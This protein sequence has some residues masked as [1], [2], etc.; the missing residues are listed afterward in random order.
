MNIEYF[1]T[2][3][4]DATV[5]DQSSYP[6]PYDCE[7]LHTIIVTNDDIDYV[8][9]EFSGDE[10]AWLALTGSATSSNSNTYP[11]FFFQK[12]NTYEIYPASSEDDLV[13]TLRYKRTVRDMSQ[14]DY[15]T[16]TIT[17]LA[18]AGTAV[19]GNG[20]TWTAGFVG[21]Y[22]KIDDDGYWYEI[23]ARTSNT[24]ITLLREYGGTAIAAGTA[25]YTIGEMSMLPEAYQDAPI[26][27]ALYM[28]YMIKEKA[29]LAA[30]YK[31]NF[32]EKLRDIKGYGSNLT[33]SGVIS[34]RGQRIINPNDYPRNLE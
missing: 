34:T 21:R 29:D 20:T 26:D 18:N 7:K 5:E 10:N 22:L 3:T 25:S 16:G 24:A 14:D 30:I 11:T 23:S 1:Y 19:T 15:T 28:Y 31:G 2:S 9:Q 8:C 33:T 32:Y 4:T 17:T 27:Y 13:M 6:L 12:R